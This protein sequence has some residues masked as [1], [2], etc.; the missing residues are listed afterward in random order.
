MRGLQPYGYIKGALTLANQSC[1]LTSF[2][3]RFKRSSPFFS[4]LFP[5]PLPLSVIIVLLLAALL[6]QSPFSSAQLTH[7]SLLT[8]IRHFTVPQ[9]KC[10]SNCPSNFAPWQHF[11]FEINHVTNASKQKKC[12]A[13]H[14]RSCYEEHYHPS[15]AHSSPPLSTL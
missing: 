15:L 13:Q 14:Q 8:P 1:Y 2:L 3:P 6:P 10:S 4:L 7:I 9:L 12:K 5:D 11:S